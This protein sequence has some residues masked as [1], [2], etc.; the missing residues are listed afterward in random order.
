[1]LS[2][3]EHETLHG[4]QRQLTVD[5]PELER[6]FDAL[7]HA[8]PAQHRWAYT[9]VIVVA[10]FLAVLSLV[11]GSPGGTFTFALIAGSVRLAQYFHDTA[12][13]RHPD[14]S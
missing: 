10:V 8:A 13:H 7:D 12:T 2:D 14:E 4:I 6:S 5:D 9:A 11:A 3:H 1:M